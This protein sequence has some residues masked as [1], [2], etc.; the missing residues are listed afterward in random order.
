MNSAKSAPVD[1]ADRVYARFFTGVTDETRMRI[2]RYLLN[3]PKIVDEIVGA[4]G[5]SQ[6]RISN[7]LSCLRWCGYE[8]AERRGKHVHYR[9]ADDSIA[10]PIRTARELVSRNAA[11]IAVCA[12]LDIKP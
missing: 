6:S 8:E 11:H 9:L 2:V 5:A 10:D 3:G 12:K 4:L 1:V 7:H